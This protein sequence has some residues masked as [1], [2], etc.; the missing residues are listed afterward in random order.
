MNA[1]RLTLLAGVGVVLALALL[2]LRPAR[3]QSDFVIE[4]AD[5]R[6]DASVAMDAAL[7]GTL[8]G[9][10]PRFILQYVNARRDLLLAAAPAPLQAALN[11]VAPR[12][13]LQY[14]NA[15]R[16]LTIA[17]PTGMDALLQAVSERIVLQ[18][19]NAKRDLMMGYP[20]EL[21]N[22]TT[23]PQLGAIEISNMADGVRVR[24]S[25][26]EFTVCV[27]SY[28]LQPG[29]YTDSIAEVY[30]SRSHEVLLPALPPGATV[31]IQ[32]AC[33]DL[34][35]NQSTSAEQ[36]LIAQRFVYLPFVSKR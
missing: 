10:T 36:S 21:I 12:F 22:D 24:W 20:K 14:V 33:T 32:N 31:Y 26:N 15:R 2:L 3:S 29:V 25:T 11:Q 27:I 5:G 30:F 28:G 35:G 4:N 16:D 9:M 34:S 7:P 23:P 13:V 8:A 18:Y 1:K 17:A 19:A 6:R